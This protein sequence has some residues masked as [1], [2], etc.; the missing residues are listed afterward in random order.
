MAD[1]IEVTPQGEQVQFVARCQGHTIT[2]RTTRAY[3]QRLAAQIMVAAEPWEPKVG[4][5]GKYTDA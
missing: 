5:D 2:L 3:A 1:G 4:Q